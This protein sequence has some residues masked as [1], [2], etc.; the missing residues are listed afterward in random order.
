MGDVRCSN[1]AI[2]GLPSRAELMIFQIVQ[3]GGA[4]PSW[5]KVLRTQAE[6]W[7]KDIPDGMEKFKIERVCS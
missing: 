1:P 4:V 2:I 5:M 7:G 3:M 6:K